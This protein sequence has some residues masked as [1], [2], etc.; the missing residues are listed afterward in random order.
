MVLQT[1]SAKGRYTISSVTDEPVTRF[2]RP[3]QPR[4]GTLYYQ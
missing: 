4:V 1:R 2:Y 3:D